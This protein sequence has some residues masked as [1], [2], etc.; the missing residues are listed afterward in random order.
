MTALRGLAEK[1]LE[2]RR[3]SKSVHALSILEKENKASRF[4]AG[5]LGG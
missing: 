2:L 1:I 4:L 5:A 3:E